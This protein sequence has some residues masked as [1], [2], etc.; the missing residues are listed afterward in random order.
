MKIHWTQ[1][2][3][4]VLDFTFQTNVV[5][6]C[7]YFCTF[8]FFWSFPAIAGCAPPPRGMETFGNQFSISRA[9]LKDANLADETLQPGFF[10][11]IRVISSKKW[12]ASSH[13]QKGWIFPQRSPT[14]RKWSYL[15]LVKDF[16]FYHSHIDWIGN[17]W[18]KSIPRVL[19]SQPRSGRDTMWSK[20]AV[21]LDNNFIKIKG[22]SWFGRYMMWLID[23]DS[24]YV[25]FM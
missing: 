1:K 8:C 2:P 25:E 7:R 17:S 3:N 15:N 4:S 10:G 20:T 21:G 11:E 23:V 6:T 12:D 16:S 5:S 14:A 13:H 24:W 9:N 18:D 19:A 22:T